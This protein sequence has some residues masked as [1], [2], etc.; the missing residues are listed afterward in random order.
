MDLLCSSLVYSRKTAWVLLAGLLLSTWAVAQEEPGKEPAAGAVEG[1]AESGSAKSGAT[2]EAAATGAASEPVDEET[3]LEDAE[4]FLQL[5]DYELAYEVFEEILE[6]DA[7]VAAARRGAAETL[8]ARG[9]YDTV[10]PLLEAA[11][12]YS[13]SPEL[14]A[15]AGRLHLRRG[16]LAAAVTA[17]QAV[18]ALDKDHIE[19]LNRL[20]ETFFRQG[21]RVEA[22]AAWNRLVG[23]YEAM[24]YEEAEALAAVGFVEMGLALVSLNRYKEA[25]DVMFAQAEEQDGSDPDL[26]LALGQVFLDKYNYPASRDAL[27]EALE[28][29]EHF[30]DALVVY[31]D[32]CLTDFQLGTRRYEMASERVERALAI[33]P[34]HA[35]AYVVRGSLWLTDGNL[36]QALEDL[37]KA[38]ELDP[39]S[40]RAWGLVATCYFLE[41]EEEKFAEVER[42]VLALNPHAAPF[43]HTIG[44]AIESK[45]RYQE[46]VRFCERAV[47]LDPDYW[48]AYVTLGINSLRTGDEERGR[49]YVKKAREKDPYSPWVLNTRYLLEHM[50]KNHKALETQHFN[51]KLPRADFDVLAAYLA[52]LLEEAYDRL[53]K[54]Y[55]VELQT[56]IYI[57]AFSTHKWFSART[58]GLE[59]F[60]ASGAC[61]GKLVT[62]TTPKAMPQNWGAVAWHEFTHVI[63]LALTEHRVPRWLTEGLS[64][65][66]EGN[67][68]PRWTRPF[69]RDIAD[70]FGSG[71][72][73]P[74]A[75]LDFG[76]SKPKYPNQIL[77]SYFQGCLIATYIS[78]KW[79]F[80]SILRILKGYRDHKGTRAIFREV[81]DLSLEEFDEQFL[82]WVG[83]WVERNGYEPIVA[84]ENISKLQLVLEA[85]E[86]D[87][88]TLVQL[89][90]AY[91]SSGN[92]LDTVLTAKKALEVDEK[93]GDAHAILGL[94]AYRDEKNPTKAKATLEKAVE[95]G[96]R[97]DF[98]AQ[99]FLGLIAQADRKNETA[100]TH[101]EKAKAISPRAGAGLGRP[102]V[103]YLLQ[104]LYQKLGKEE[105]AV[106]QMEE[107][108][109]FAVEDARCRRTIADYY[110]KRD[111]DAGAAKALT[112]LEQLVFLQPF[113]RSLHQ[114]LGRLGVRLERH[115][116]TVRAYEYLLRYPDANPK[117]AYAALA[118]A[119]AGL[120]NAPA[121]RSYAR[122]LLRLDPANGEAKKILSEL[123]EG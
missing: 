18:L 87:L 71:R 37:K 64:V 49:E 38:V 41:G 118:R 55:Q 86:N 19:A 69:D 25:N 81:F 1:S 72:L 54:R 32:N 23:V 44:K 89:T 109:V 27:D 5:G 83:E 105:L 102:N 53:S 77:I 110:L 80:D 107:L 36:V 20:G 12:D 70:A 119:H 88:P 93:N 97:Y 106:L 79:G 74:L 43:F 85:K 58:V 6:A 61:F 39:S 51:I 28:Q 50:D 99:L 17:F 65:L 66:E 114:D 63:T 82:V 2:E 120:G 46:V 76:F 48:P 57:E 84:P 33:N 47:A 95:L 9:Q 117:I 98:R 121:A 68:H 116:T 115:E 78:E 30:A 108:S 31:A 91:Y 112:A 123:G 75:E 60:A 15:M 100:V 96:T 92:D 29:N 13:K 73:L 22:E 10:S 122:R 104:E 16:Q 8:I 21:K 14:L 52:P 111:D 40:L 4:T 7:T 67:D 34:Q 35:G 113:D 45:F 3:P 90:W 24:T 59:G 101:L 103:Y 94:T 62:L 56:P 26:L 42:Q 11:T